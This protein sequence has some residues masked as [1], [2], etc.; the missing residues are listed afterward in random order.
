MKHLCDRIMQYFSGHTFLS[1]H[2]YTVLT[3][4]FP[5]FPLD[6]HLKIFGFLGIWG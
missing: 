2:N 3:F 4:F 6:K 1:L 5:M